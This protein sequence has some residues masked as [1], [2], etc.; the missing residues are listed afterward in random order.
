MP[1]DYP[2]GEMAFQRDY[3]IAFGDNATSGDS[4]RK[5]FAA[6]QAEARSIWLQ[7]VSPAQSAAADEPVPPVAPSMSAAVQEPAPCEPCEPYEPFEPIE[8][9]I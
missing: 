2:G 4:E 1:N 7:R 3:G 9:A 8:A 6:S 5:H